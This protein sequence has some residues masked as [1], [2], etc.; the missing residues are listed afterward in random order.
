MENG[1]LSAGQT[2]LETDMVKPG[3]NGID[4]SRIFISI[5]GDWGIVE[6]IKMEIESNSQTDSTGT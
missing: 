2:W 6:L 4:M 1:G 3:A 5:T